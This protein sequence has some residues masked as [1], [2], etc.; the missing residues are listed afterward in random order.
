M[1]LPFKQSDLAQRG[2]AI[3]CRIYAEDPAAG[4]VPAPGKIDTLRFPDGPGVR[5][6][7]G[8]YEGA[9]VSLYYDPMIAKLATWGRDRGEA[10]DRMRR[11]LAE[12]TIAGE[13][14]TNLEFHRWIVEQP[15]FL[16]GDFDTNY[17]NQEYH[18][19]KLMRGEDPTRLA[20]ILAAAVTAQHNQNHTVAAPS[21]SATA[22]AG[23]NGGSA[24][25]TLGR[26]DMLRR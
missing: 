16:A 21:T 4:F 25:K 17:I 10:I 11:A 19:E 23:A 26:I 13:L 20:A 22:R 3:E 1:P 2:W 8:V 18:P 7:A 15:G 14:T 9:E 6:D 5:I 24:W 12:C